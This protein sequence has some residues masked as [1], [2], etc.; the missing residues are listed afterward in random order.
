[1]WTAS[2]TL[3]T[4]L[5]RHRQQQQEGASFCMEGI[6]LAGKEEKALRGS[7]R[8]ST[9]ETQQS[10]VNFAQCH[11][12]GRSQVLTQQSWAF[13][14]LAWLG[15]WVS[16]VVLPAGA[17]WDLGEYMGSLLSKERAGGLC[18]QGKS[19]EAEGEVVIRTKGYELSKRKLETAWRLPS[20]NEVLR[21]FPGRRRRELGAL[22]K[23]LYHNDTET[24]IVPTGD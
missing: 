3:H 13:P 5:P 6:T 15:L 24:L 16:F 2:A 18:Q 11:G 14:A 21:R 17:S 10:Q 22:R 19:W 1:M 8:F 9:E 4:P 12:T 7:G 20:S 23:G